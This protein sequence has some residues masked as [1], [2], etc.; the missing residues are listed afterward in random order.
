MKSRMTFD[1]KT[2][3]LDIPDDILNEMNGC[4]LCNKPAV[5]KKN[6]NGWMVQACKEHFDK[7]NKQEV[8]LI[9]KIMKMVDIEDKEHKK[10]NRNIKKMK[11]N[12]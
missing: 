5:W 10:L 4:I 8:G 2:G 11:M 6:E 7:V 1:P 3:N 12:L 9:N